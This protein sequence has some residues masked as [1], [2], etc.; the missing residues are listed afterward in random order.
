MTNRSD[1]LEK[2]RAANPVPASAS[3][4]VRPDLVLYDRILVGTVELP[5]R[6]RPVRR[7]PRALV[8]ALVLSS[9]LGGAVAYAALTGGVSRPQSVACY[10]SASLG[11]RTEVVHAAGGGPVEA[12]A[13]LWRRGVLGAGGDAPLLALC[14]LDSGV[15]GVFPA[16]TGDDVCAHLGLATVPSTVPPSAPPPG[17]PASDADVNERFLAF[18]DTVLPQFLDARCMDPRTGAAIVRR[19]L[20]TA[21]LPGW[22]VVGAEGGAG[23]GFTADRPCASLAFHP[24]RHEVAL[25]PAPPRP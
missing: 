24:E 14:L 15:A 4:V 22:T 23:D 18:R 12:C 25:V 2:L 1:P 9:L 17:G 16:T 21:G 3:A 5:G 10:E 8:P 11:A 6:A 19:E 13:D 7:R 20:A